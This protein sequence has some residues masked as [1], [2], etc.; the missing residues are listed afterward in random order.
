MHT[1]KRIFDLLAHQQLNYPTFPMF[2]K[3]YDEIS[4]L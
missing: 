3:Q 1:P 4:G 2:F